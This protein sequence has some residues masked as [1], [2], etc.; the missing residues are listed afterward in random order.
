MR[1]EATAVA[2]LATTPVAVAAGRCADRIADIVGAVAVTL[3]HE[4]R[5]CLED[6][7][8]A[9]AP[10]IV[11]VY[12]CDVG[13]MTL[14]RQ[15]EDDLYHEKMARGFVMKFKRGHV[16]SDKALRQRKKAGIA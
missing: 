15:I 7:D 16:M 6:P 3:D 2:L 8:T 9:Y 14:S 13:T 12:R 11:G 10:H 1:D 5:V 4:G